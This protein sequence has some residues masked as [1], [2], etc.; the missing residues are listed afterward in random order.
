MLLKELVFALRQ[1]I[2]ETTGDKPS[3]GHTY[4]LLSALLGYDSFASLNSQ[5]FI[6]SLSGC[7]G[8]AV[9][10]V[11]L[12]MG[13]ILDLRRATNR[14]VSLKASGPPRPIA[15]VVETFAQQHELVAIPLTGLLEL[16]DGYEP[17]CDISQ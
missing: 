6:V 3:T 17:L 8:N 2:A 15:Q 9:E 16:C 5:A 13:G 12:L 7:D 10:N 11:R 4:E 1:L 14:H